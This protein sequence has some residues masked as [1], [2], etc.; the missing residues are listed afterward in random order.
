M[1]IITTITLYA[2]NPN[3]ARQQWR[4]EWPVLTSLLVADIA[5]VGSLS[6]FNPKLLGVCL[7]SLCMAIWYVLMPVLASLRGRYLTEPRT[8]GITAVWWLL[9]SSFFIS[10]FLVSVFT[11]L[12][13]R[14]THIGLGILPYTAVSCCITYAALHVVKRY[15]PG[16]WR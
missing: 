12:V 4:K 16:V 7:S 2:Y 3:T 14:H 8:I 15:M 13:E 5:F 11:S 6:Y 1:L 9:Y 10:F